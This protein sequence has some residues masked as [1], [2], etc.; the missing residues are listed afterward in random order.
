[1]PHMLSPSWQTQITHPPMSLWPHAC[2]GQDNPEVHTVLEMGYGR[3]ELAAAVAAEGLR[4]LLPKRCPAGYAALTAAC[5]ER[6]PHARPSFAEVARALERLLQDEL[7]AVALQ[8]QAQQRHGGK[9]SS[10]SAVSDVAV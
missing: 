4:P 3:Q 6:E 8:Q 10:P 5:W 7:D 1:M 9:A 2:I